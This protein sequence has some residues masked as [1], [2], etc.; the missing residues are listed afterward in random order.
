MRMHIDTKGC[1]FQIGAGRSVDD[2]MSDYRHYLVLYVGDS[3]I[4]VYFSTAAELKSACNEYGLEYK[5]QRKQ[6]EAE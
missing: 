1:P 4:Y 3:M 5:D 6:V 2:P